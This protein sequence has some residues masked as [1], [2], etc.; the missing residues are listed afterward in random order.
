MFW[1]SPLTLLGGLPTDG[2]EH[3]AID[4]TFLAVP[5]NKGILGAILVAAFFLL[6]L[7]RLAKKYRSTE[8]ICLLALT[9]YLF[10]ENKPFLLSANPFL[11]LAPIVFLAGLRQRKSRTKP[12]LNP[13]TAPAVW[14]AVAVYKGKI[15][16]SAG[17]FSG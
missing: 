1:G 5:M 2:D 10:M 13:K 17:R 14:R 3:H 11:L 12:D 15:N 7:W 6:L 8:T 16:G 4:N 9:L